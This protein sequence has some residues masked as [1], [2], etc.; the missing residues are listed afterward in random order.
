MAKFTVDTHLFR[1]LG[2]LLVGRDSTAL[3][4]LIKNSYD[5]DATLV[6]IQGQNLAQP[7]IGRITIS[8]NG[9]GMTRLQFESGFLRVASRIKEQGDR[10]SEV[11]KRRYTGAKGI[12]R[13]AAHKLACKIEMDSIPPAKN[14]RQREALH[15]SI[16]WD[17]VEKYETLEDIDAS[18]AILIESSLAHRDACQGTMLVLTQLRRPWTPVER[19]RFF[20]E[21]QSFAPPRFLVNLPISV[22]G[23]EGLFKEPM[24]RDEQPQTNHQESGFRVELEGDFAS[25]DE[26]WELVA[27]VTH[28]VL[29]IKAEKDGKVH[30][31]VSPTKKTTQENPDARVIRTSIQHPSPNEGPFFHSR[32]LV[33][34]GRRTGLPGKRDVL[35]WWDKASGIRVYMEGFRVLP[36]GEPKNDWLGLDAEYTRRPRQLEML[37]ELCLDAEEGDPDE[38]LS[39]LPS[40]NYFGAVFLTQERAQSLRTLVNRE[41]FVP[42][43]G[44]ETLVQIL[45]TGVHLC[46]RVRAAAAMA[47][48]QKWQDERW[49]RWVDIDGLIRPSSSTISPVRRAEENLSL[50]NRLAEV[51]KLINEA[52]THVSA[53]H[54]EAG[55]KAASAAEQELVYVTEI[56]ADVTSERTLLRVLAAVGTQ[57]AAF[58]HEINGLLGAAQ[59][60]ETALGELLTDN[61]FPREQRLNI[62]LIYSAVKELKHRLERQA[63][64]LVDVVTPDSRRRRSRQSLCQRFDSAIRLIQHQAEGRRIVI[65]NKIPLDLMS[66]PMFPAELTSIFS[67]LL[68]NAIKAVDHDGRI[69]AAATEDPERIT[70]VIQNTGA[71]IDL[72]EAERWFKP[73]ESTT[74]QVDPVL[75]QGMGLGLTITRIILSS[76]GATIGFVSPSHE[77]ATAVEVVFPK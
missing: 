39:L 64:Y 66:P 44:Y 30:F 67:N 16:D 45:R 9:T 58:V 57:M 29:E 25:G 53:G 13:L 12:G 24:V 61:S 70:V 17:I 23:G 52:R 34:E 59:T 77:F 20:A 75:G 62:E 54:V 69:Y 14:G 50:S 68:T 22:L 27:E 72:N 19:A 21:V 56:A 74:S 26:Y 15:A 35:V 71:A 6:I 32:I 48:R 1:E 7:Q 4:E 31:L 5:A 46:T 28:W 49:N 40:N 63:S 55:Q 8:D 60:V 37:Q 47:R 36:Y 2:E 33:R 43:A 10:R 18:N 11:F 76:Y 38:G 51:S 3:I 41:G 73:F 65:E 42:E